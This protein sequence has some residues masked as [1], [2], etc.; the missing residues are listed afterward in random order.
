MMDPYFI[1]ILDLPI[2]WITEDGMIRWKNHAAEELFTSNRHDLWSEFVD[3]LPEGYIYRLHN[4]N[5]GKDPGTLIECIPDTSSQL[6]QELHRL[7]NANE[8]LE[9]LFNASF[10]EV[11]VTD[12]NG[13]TLRVNEATKRLYGLSEHEL[14]GKSVYELESQGVF[15][16]S[17]TALALR[18]R[19]RITILQTTKDGKKL[20]TTA[21][22]IFDADNNIV[23][24]ISNAKDMSE[25]P[26]N[27]EELD[28]SWISADHSFFSFSDDLLVTQSA[29]AKMKSIFQIL[30]KV[31]RTNAT[32]L[33]QGETGVGK[34]RMAQFI[35]STSLCKGTF[36][37]VDCTAIPETLFESELFG[38]ERGSFTGANK[39]GKAGMLEQAELGTLFLDEIGEIP[40]Q[41]Q[42]K[43]LTFLQHKT[44][45]R[46]GGN[47]QIHVNTRIVVA[48]N[49]DLE[50][51]VEKGAFRSDLYFRLNVIPIQI[52][53][54]R[55]RLED[56]ENICQSLLEK[57]SQTYEMPVK[58]LTREVLEIL[59][60]YSW[61]GNIRELEHLLERLILTV[62]AAQ[63]TQT[64]LPS[65]FSC[66]NMNMDK[67]EMHYQN[68]DSNQKK[69][70]GFWTN[71]KPLAELLA[72]YEKEI[73]MQA[74][75]E[76]ASTY[77]IA[78]QLD[79]SQPTVVRKLKLY[80]IR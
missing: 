14:I 64:D 19:K 61:P 18:Q 33:L 50:K 17:V 5:L 32:I 22:P 26:L 6:V 51:M 43:L 72:A 71:E 69:K 38:Y 16:P 62:D 63:I 3:N 58:H 56:L 31:S 55:E 46:I 79:V 67:M 57:L 78:K 9:R 80:G 75:A 41:I 7:R 42:G 44:F 15:Y 21:N 48:T 49:R 65:Q 29:N 2:F 27:Q 34:D 11:F 30:H 8:E 24:V 40:L 25:M 54:L 52:P 1:D 35:H 20:L 74:A 76:N 45:K 66:M 77:S 12:G 68:S 59:K 39:T 4:C 13:V 70:P 73:Y 53:A 10:D 23:Q 36:V 37:R 28:K 47:R 60:R